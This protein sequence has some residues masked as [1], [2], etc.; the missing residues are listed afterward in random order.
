M[1]TKNILKVTHLPFEAKKKCYEE[2]NSAEILKK[3]SFLGQ[4]RVKPA[5]MCTHLSKAPDH[6]IGLYL[7]RDQNQHENYPQMKRTKQR[8]SAVGKLSDCHLYIARSSFII[9]WE[10]SFLI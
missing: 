8:S 6:I 10:F 1:N 4:T 7:A 5:G 9:S 2:K 3:V